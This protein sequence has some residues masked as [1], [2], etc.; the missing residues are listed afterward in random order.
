MRHSAS[1]SLALVLLLGLAS[2][3][4]AACGSDPPPPPKAPVPTAATVDMPPPPAP[5][6]EE[7]VKAEPPKP[8]LAEL[9]AKAI[10]GYLEAMN[11]HDA[12]KLGALYTDDAEWKMAG[13]PPT[14]GRATIEA[15]VAKFFAFAPDVKLAPN[16]ILSKGDVTVLQYAITGTNKGDMGPIKPTNKPIGWQAMHI[17]WWT[18]EGK[19]REEHAYWDNGTMLSQMGI[20]PRKAPAIPTLAASPQTVAASGS[21]AETKNVALLGTMYGAMEKKSATDF[22]SL[23]TD[24]S[25][26]I[27]NTQPAPSKG[28]AD[29]QKFFDNHMKAFPDAKMT[30]KSSWGIG[31]FVVTE[32]QM[33]GTNTGPLFGRPATKKAVTMDTADIV[34]L[35]DGKMVK[36]WSFANG[37]QVAEQLGML[38]KHG[39][40]KGHHEHG[41]G[42]HGKGAPKPAPKP[43]APKKK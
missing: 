23:T 17:A 39:G 40:G 25:E 20:S 43:A 37:M 35:K 26:W 15:E 2:A 9:Q 3:G 14:K 5:K 1:S 7:P 32:A 24:T 31:D 21:E 8:T 10:A 4:S 19:I 42:E 18:P 28:K 29:A 11:S 12:A 13:T 33:T 34:L 22:L 16:L 38:P 41:K 36:G 27:D 6:V 30:V